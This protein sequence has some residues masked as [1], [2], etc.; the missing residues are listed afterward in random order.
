[1]K[2]SI[3]LKV[4]LSYD[5]LPV[6]TQFAEQV[7]IAYGLSQND[8][9]RSVLACEDVYTYLTSHSNGISDLTLNIKECGY[10]IQITFKFS[11]ITIPLQVLNITAISDPG[12]PKCLAHLEIFIAAHVVDR[13][14]LDQNTPDETVVHLIIEKQ[15]PL[16][17]ESNLDALPASLPNL[18]CTT[19][20][21]E[22]IKQAA[23][24]IIQT[25][26]SHAP[27]F[28][29]YPGKI[30]DMIKSGEMQAAV[31]SDGKG[32]VAG[33]ILWVEGEHLIEVHG[34]YVFIA[35]HKPG[36]ELTSFLLESVGRSGLKSLIIRDPLPGV[37]ES[38]FEKLPLITW[39]SPKIIQEKLLDS[40]MPLYRQLEEDIGATVVVHPDFTQVVSQWYDQM[41]LPRILIS[42]LP[43]GEAPDEFTVFAVRIDNN[44]KIASLTLR[45]VGTDAPLTLTAHTSHLSKQGISGIT[46][47]MD[48]S[49]EMEVFLVPVLLKTG[50]FPSYII[51]WGGTGDVLVFY[52]IGETL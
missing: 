22:E 20:T 28:C 48:L 26:G 32:N 19:G 3:E 13:F 38:W 47:E 15:Y 35:G 27:V 34:P 21:H 2:R 36:E 50:F 12:D 44:R 1:M 31:Y 10:Y 24:R 9:K 30:L 18:S 11:P 8:I 7:V 5:I 41:D 14:I 4:P 42:S 52:Y 46:Y 51:P 17:S 23:I 43:A 16:V 37:P 39:N 40:C 33:C 45:T 49:N 29:R 6:I 25:Y